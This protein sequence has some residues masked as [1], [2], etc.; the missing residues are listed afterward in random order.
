MSIPMQTWPIRRQGSL[1]WI[2]TALVILQ[3]LRQNK[4]KSITS[5]LYHSLDYLLYSAVSE[6]GNTRVSY[7]VI[8][9]SCV[10][11]SPQMCTSHCSPWMLTLLLSE[12]IRLWVPVPRCMTVKLTA[13]LP[14][15]DSTEPRPLRAQGLSRAE[16]V[17]LR[18][19][20]CARPTDICCSIL[21]GGAV[22]EA[23]CIAF[24]F[25]R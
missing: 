7:F 22:L 21:Q 5:S 3:G 18:L 24:L 2:I 11:D 20:S 1:R 9:Q 25:I 6:R 16:G 19:W 4:I 17:C 15:P 13:V 10:T 8:H 14:A 12:W 23:G